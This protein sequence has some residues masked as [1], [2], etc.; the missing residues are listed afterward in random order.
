MCRCRGRYK[1]E[2]RQQNACLLA[3]GAATERVGWNKVMNVHAGSGG[4]RGEARARLYVGEEI[5]K[6]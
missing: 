1:R 3:T 2:E 4:R 5:K 6:Q